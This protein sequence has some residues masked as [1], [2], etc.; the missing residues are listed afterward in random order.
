MSKE[1]PSPDLVEL[2]QEVFD[3][4][5]RQDFD[6]ALSRF[7]L[8]AVWESEGLEASFKGVEA[9]REFMLRWSAAYAA[10]ELQAEDIHALGGDVVLCVFMNRPTGGVSEPS[11]RFALV[12]VWTEGLVRR[13]IGTEDVAGARA[14]ADNLAAERRSGGA[15][16]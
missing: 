3:A 6:G 14:T 11:L 15:M 7:A 1:S 4:V 16:D 5:D 12:I 13:V 2:T 8:D 10:F 9:I